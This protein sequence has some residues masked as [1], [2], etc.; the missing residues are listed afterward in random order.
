MEGIYF[1]KHVGANNPIQG[2][3]GEQ[4]A[5]RTIVLTT[6]EC[7]I[8]DSGAYAIDVDIVIDLLGDRATNFTP[9]VGEWI[10]A[11]ITSVAREYNGG[12]F[13]ENRLARYVKL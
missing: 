5:K 2:K 4:V 13:G 11:S 9:Q 8:G 6:K 7:R 1:V 12:F 10:V 3:N